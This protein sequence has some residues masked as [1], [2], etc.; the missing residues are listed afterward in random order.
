MKA[1]SGRETDTSG[2]RKL[3]LCSEY[4]YANPDTSGIANRITKLLLSHNVVIAS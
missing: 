3:N 2:A 4:L 1:Q